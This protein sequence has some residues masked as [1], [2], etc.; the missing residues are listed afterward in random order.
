MGT[1]H[2]ELSIL[3]IAD[4]RTLLSVNKCFGQT[5]YVHWLSPPHQNRFV[6]ETMWKNTVQYSAVQY[7]TVQYS[8]V[9]YSTVQ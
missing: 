8:T 9:Q 3:M 7:S 2:D 6:Y 5:F 1:L 4:R